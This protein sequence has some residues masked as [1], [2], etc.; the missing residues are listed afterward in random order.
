[1]QGCTAAG[2]LGAVR[3]ALPHN[4]DSIARSAGT[5]G[6]DAAAKHAAAAASDAARVLPE[7]AAETVARSA[8]ATC[9]R[10]RHVSGMHWGLGAISGAGAWAACS[11]VGLNHLSSSTGGMRVHILP[12]SPPNACAGSFHTVQALLSKL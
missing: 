8:A 1:M 5:R 4:N 7:Q 10:T 3:P 12:C 6:D 2:V 9:T 11:W